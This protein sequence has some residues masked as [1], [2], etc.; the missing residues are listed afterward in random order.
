MGTPN[1]AYYGVGSYDWQG[2]NADLQPLGKI[3]TLTP[4]TLTHYYFEGDDPIADHYGKP[5]D[6]SVKLWDLSPD[7]SFATY[8]YFFSSDTDNLDWQVGTSDNIQPVP[9]VMMAKCLDGAAPSLNVGWRK[10]PD[11]RYAYDRS[12]CGNALSQSSQVNQYS[13][14]VSDI[15]YN[16]YCIYTRVGCMEYSSNNIQIKYATRS[17]TDNLVSYINADPEHRWVTY[18]ANTLYYGNSTERINDIIYVDADAEDA[19]FGRPAYRCFPVADAYADRPIPD[20]A[21]LRDYIKEGHSDWVG[22]KVFSPFMYFPTYSGSPTWFGATGNDYLFSNTYNIGMSRSLTRNQ[23]RD[24]INNIPGTSYKI[25]GDWLRCNFNRKEFDDVAYHWEVMMWEP[26]NNFE[27][28]NGT[29]AS[30]ISTNQ[31]LRLFTKLIIDDTK[32]LTIGEATLRA[33]LHENAYIGFYFV[34]TQSLA[35]SGVLGSESNGVNIYLPK[36]VNGIP[37]G[38]YYTGDEI[39]DV[40]YADADSVNNEYFRYDPEDSESDSG[41]LTTRFLRRS[42]EGSAHLWGFDDSMMRQ[43]VN[44]LNTDYTPDDADFIADFKGTNP[45]DY[46][47]SVKYFPFPLPQ[48][49]TFLPI[50][51]GRITSGFFGYKIPRE[52]GAPSS[53]YD[54]GSWRLEPPYIDT[55]FRMNYTKLMLYIPWCGYT[56]LDTPVFAP[57][58]DGTTHTIGVKMSID[59]TTGSCL[60]M[61]LRDN[62]VIQTVNGTCGVDIPLMA[63]SQGSYQNDIKQT[64]LALKQAE[65]ARLVS[66]IKLGGSL[67]PTITAG[68]TFGLP[69]AAAKATKDSGN[70][71]S[72]ALDNLSAVRTAEGIEYQLEHT[73]PSVDTISAASPFNNI[74]IEPL[75]KLFIYKPVMMAGYDASAYAKTVGYACNRSGILSTFRGLTVCATANLSSINCTASEQSMIASLLT[76][77]VI[78]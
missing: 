65:T 17:G 36:R 24:G 56:I 68:T 33:V 35:S 19:S 27:I 48:D 72:A 23:W 73:A 39:A 32:G 46:I 74:L 2:Y 14:L 41:D 53:L 66:G 75:P 44:W 6:P 10:Q 57:S 71:V 37:N 25:Y 58:P 60:G 62:T 31:N 52:I 59:Y 20:Y 42:L 9:L 4:K 21:P 16:G 63:L 49:T 30:V 28:P 7:A 22:D 15:T 12:G 47:V 38:E 64:E 54:F 40:P 78:I 13:R 1:I 43:L 76:S 70:I 11:I 26:F 8:C 51:I 45:N 34:P 67:I 55:D 61:I 3:A 18:L 50:K 77:G 69:A 29:P 5:F